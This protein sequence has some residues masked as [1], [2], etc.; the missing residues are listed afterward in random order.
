MPT[1]EEEPVEELDPI[2]ERAIHRTRGVIGASDRMPIRVIVLIITILVCV[3]LSP[4]PAN[5]IGLAA[6]T[7]LAI[8]IT[9]HRR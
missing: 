8:D 6:L 1:N 5:I 9:Q 4:T 7:L 2:I 3:T